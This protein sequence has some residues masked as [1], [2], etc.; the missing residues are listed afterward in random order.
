[1]MSPQRLFMLVTNLH[2]CFD[3]TGIGTNTRN[4]LSPNS[5]RTNPTGTIGRCHTKGFLL[6]QGQV[7]QITGPQ[8]VA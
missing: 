7:I 8:T 1:M 3:N 4:R 2:D 6:D 5:C